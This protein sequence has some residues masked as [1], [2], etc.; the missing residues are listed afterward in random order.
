MTLYELIF[1]IALALIFARLFGYIF[2]RIHLPVVIGEIFA[3]ILLGLVSLFIFTGQTITFF[4]I[5]IHLPTLDF[6]SVEFNEIA[7]VGILFLMFISGLTMNIQKFKDIEKSSTFVAIGGVVIPF[8]LGYLCGIL[9]G[10]TLG[11]SII[12]GLILTATSVGITVRTLMDLHILDSHPGAV[13]IG[14]A[15]MDDVIGVILLAFIIGTDPTVYVALKV[16]LFFVI[17][18]YIGLRFIDRILGLGEKIPLPKAFLSIGLAIFFLLTFFA[19]L[20]GISAIIGAFIAGL[21]IGQSLKSRK[22]INDVE[23]IGYGLLVPMF[24]IWIGVQFISGI[25]SDATIFLSIWLFCVVFVF[26]GIVGKIIGCGIGGRLTGLSKQ[27]S[28]QIGVGMVPRMELAIIII[29]TAIAKGV[30]S[31]KIVEHQLLTAVVM[32]TFATTLI[33]PFLIKKTFKSQRISA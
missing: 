13:I 11:D 6:L 16:F 21:L 9:F 31:S 30:I 27:E 2:Y 5:V 20:F 26:V 29:S 19:H 1:L 32:L 22:I 8:L 12:I 33:T 10:F 23:S 24:F 4:S 17:F 15:I 14:S 25:T 7:Q 3:G 28:L 18:L